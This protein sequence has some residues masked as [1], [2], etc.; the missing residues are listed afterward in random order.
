MI[1]TQC[2]KQ[3]SSVSCNNLMRHLCRHRRWPHAYPNFFLT[4]FFPSSPPQQSS[5]STHR[6][7]TFSR[8]VS[9]FCHF[10][11]ASY[12]TYGLSS[13]TAQSYLLTYEL[14][15]AYL[16]TTQVSRYQNSMLFTHSRSILIF[17]CVASKVRPHTF[18]AENRK[19]SCQDKVQFVALGE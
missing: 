10:C 18:V 2:V 11:L 9:F 7:V 19:R 6:A 4:F 8:F 3:T 16:L 13:L 5:I 1:M 15:V 12:K 14:R 17:F